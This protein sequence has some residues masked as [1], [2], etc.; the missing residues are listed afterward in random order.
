M[1]TDYSDEE[2]DGMMNMT[3]KHSEKGS[4]YPYGSS[5]AEM[6]W[7]LLLPQWIETFP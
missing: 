1:L 6:L 5:R 3:L 2:L 7:N 4:C